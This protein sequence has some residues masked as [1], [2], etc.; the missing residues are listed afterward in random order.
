M[1]QSHKLAL[2]H[3]QCFISVYGLQF[4]MWNRHA[5]IHIYCAE[6]LAGEHMANPV[7]CPFTGLMERSHRATTQE[8]HT[9]VIMLALAKCIRY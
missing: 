5:F 6:C 3:G 2:L 9:L 8:G 1:L 7:M 4:K